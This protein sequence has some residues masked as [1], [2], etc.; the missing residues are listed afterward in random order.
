MN[1]SL[2]EMID[3]VFNRADVLDMVCGGTHDKRELVDNLPISRPTIDRAIRELEEHDL[4]KRSG[5]TCE[6]TFSGRLALEM[7]EITEETID[8]IH[9]KSEI[10]N[11]LS[12]NS[13][14]SPLLLTEASIHLPS[15]CAPFSPIEP[16]YTKLEKADAL[17]SLVPVILPHQLELLHRKSNASNEN[18]EVTIDSQI[19]ETLLEQHHERTHEMIS[20]GNTLYKADRL[21]NYS[22]FICDGKFVFVTIYSPTNQPLG[23]I[24]NS[25]EA[26]LQWAREQ[27]T[28]YRKNATPLTC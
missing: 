25:S 12:K 7:Y 14:I 5:G 9:N 26:V 19:L 15:D 17:R 22:L 6:P 11:E 4:V 3:I 2:Q 13:N 24:E 20:N 23:V 1:S 8:T 21:P 16:V 10:L 28:F 18:V 27:F